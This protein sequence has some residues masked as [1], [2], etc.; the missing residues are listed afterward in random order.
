MDFELALIDMDGTVY[1]GNTPI[2][3]VNEALD[4]LSEKGVETLFLTNYAGD[5]RSSYSEKLEKMGIDASS[6]DVVTSGWLTAG[7]V[8]REFPE[9][10][11]FVLGEEELRQEFQEQGL[12]VA[13]SCDRPDVL[14]ISNK[15]D[16][17]YEDLKEVIQG[18]DDETVMLGTNPDTTIPGDDG[19]IPGAGAFI[20]TVEAMTGREIEV[21]GKPS[22]DAVRTV[23]GMKDVSPEKCLMVGDNLETDIRMGFENGM[24]TVLVLTGVTDRKELGDSEVS[25]DHVIESIAELETLLR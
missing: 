11:V 1:S 6:E 25:P 12:K 14:V 7:Y 5:A 22:K 23:T 13:E 8:S 16:L 20:A 15:H 2:E 4:F 18:I 3:G 9:A 21:I 19:E 10:E 24:E 17:T